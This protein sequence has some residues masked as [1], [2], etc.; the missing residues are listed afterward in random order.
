MGRRGQRGHCQDRGDPATTPHLGASRSRLTLGTI[1]TTET[2][3]GSREKGWGVRRGPSVRSGVPRPLNVTSTGWGG[4]TL[5]PFMPGRPAVPGRPRA[6]WGKR[7]VVMEVLGGLSP[8]H[9]TLSPRGGQLGVSPCVSHL[10]AGGTPLSGAAGLASFTLRTRTPR[11]W[12]VPKPGSCC[13]PG[14]AGRASRPQTGEGT[15][16][17]GH[18][19]HLR[20]CQGGRRDLGDPWDPRREGGQG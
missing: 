2:L 14:G 1:Q 17:T 13:S 3:G 18:L 5:C 16:W 15:P 4:L 20:S 8:R 6:P 19:R 7:E 12:H 11:W 9:S 10:G